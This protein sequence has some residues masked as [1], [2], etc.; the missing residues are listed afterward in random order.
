M[1]ENAIGRAKE[2]FAKL[3]VEQLERVDRMKD[4]EDWVDY[5]K[6]TSIIIGVCG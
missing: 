2:H 6:L 5:D 3:L 1:D 4:G